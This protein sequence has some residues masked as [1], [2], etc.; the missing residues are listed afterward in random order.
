MKEYFPGGKPLGHVSRDRMR[1]NNTPPLSSS[2]P[3][4]PMAF[5]PCEQQLTLHTIHEVIGINIR[6]ALFY[7]RLVRSPETFGGSAIQNTKQAARRARPR[8]RPVQAPPGG[9]CRA[10]EA[11]AHAPQAGQ[12]IRLGKL[13][14]HR[15]GIGSCPRC[16]YRSAL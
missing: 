8:W 16:L 13:H 9:A 5:L 6:Q 1:V 7:V 2:S 3:L 11:V 12:S 4:G 10:V 14:V 15:N